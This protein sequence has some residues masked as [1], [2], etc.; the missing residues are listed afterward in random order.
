MFNERYFSNLH[1]MIIPLYGFNHYHHANNNEESAEKFLKYSRKILDGNYEMPDGI[2]PVKV[3]RI[4]T[5][6]YVYIVCDIVP[7]IREFAENANYFYYYVT[8]IK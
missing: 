2:E 6:V 5:P 7:K 1:N 3:D 8:S 4:N